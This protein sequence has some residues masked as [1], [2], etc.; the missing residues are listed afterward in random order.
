MGVGDGGLASNNGSAC[1]S[2][3]STLPFLMAQQMLRLLLLIPTSIC[4][5]LMGAS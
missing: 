5:A 1:S 3:R 2:L 4:E